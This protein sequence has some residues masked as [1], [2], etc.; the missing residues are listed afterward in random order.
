MPSWSGTETTR[1]GAS[2][3]LHRRIGSR[4]RFQDYLRDYR[5]RLKSKASERPGGREQEADGEVQPDG[6]NRAPADVV[7][8]GRHRS[9]PVL[10]RELYRILRGHRRAIALAL[11]GLSASTLLKLVPP[12]ATKAVID[13]V[14]LARPLPP[15]M[16]RWSPLPIPDSP[17]L[18]LLILVGAGFGDHDPGYASRALEPL[19]GDADHQARA[20]R[21][22]EESL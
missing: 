7:P 15:S 18:R 9:L 6:G 10:Y 5:K 2:L 3:S 11:L 8:A 17:R 19:D 20:S 13:Y 1:E 22:P 12:A 14:L 4:L 16:E 21:G